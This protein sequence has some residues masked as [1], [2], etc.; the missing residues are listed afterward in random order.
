[1]PNLDTK[2]EMLVADFLIVCS[3]S[4]VLHEVQSYI[5]NISFPK[6]LEALK[7][8]E[9]NGKLGIEVLIDGAEDTSWTAPKRAKA[10]DIVF[11]MYSVNSIHTIRRL[12]REVRSGLILILRLS[13]SMSAGTARRYR[14]RTRR[15]E[16]CA[17]SGRRLCGRKEVG[18]G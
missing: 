3:Y 4:D 8:A 2:H 12:K 18:T 9:A 13:E 1:M 16:V 17:L 6:T 15:Q 5:I 7:N 11:F 14:S 10:G